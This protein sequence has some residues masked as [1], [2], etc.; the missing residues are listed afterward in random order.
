MPT[1]V[2]IQG[3]EAFSAPCTSEPPV[4]TDEEIA[5]LLQRYPTAEEREREFWATRDLDHRAC[6]A[7]ERR[8][9]DGLLALGARFNQAVRD[10]D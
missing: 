5:A 8:R 3:L 4:L 6:S 2:E 7:Y 9:A 1:P 10:G